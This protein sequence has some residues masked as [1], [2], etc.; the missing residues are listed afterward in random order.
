MKKGGREFTEE[1]IAKLRYERFHHP[2]PR[3]QRKMKTLL[4]KSAG[5]PHNQIARIVGISENTLRDYLR[6]YKEGG[7]ER[8]K[9]LR[10]HNP[11]SELAEHRQ[12]LETY[13]EQHRV[14]WSYLGSVTWG[15]PG[16]LGVTHNRLRVNPGL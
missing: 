8:L 7:V 9:E 13:F 2:H 15:H 10:F 6:E 5:L 1:A 4:L 14:T 12:S 11:R 16:L 3:V